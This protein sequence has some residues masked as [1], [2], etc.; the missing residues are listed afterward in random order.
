MSPIA[1]FKKTLTQQSENNTLTQWGI[2]LELAAKSRSP[3]VSSQEIKQHGQVGIGSAFRGNE[4]SGNFFGGG[5]GFLFGSQNFRVTRGGKA[6]E[7]KDEEG[8][9]T[10]QVADFAGA[11]AISDSVGQEISGRGQLLEMLK[12]KSGGKP[13]VAVFDAKLHKGSFVRSNGIFPEDE[14]ARRAKSTFDAQADQTR[15][16][17][18]VGGSGNK[19]DLLSLRESLGSEEAATNDFSL[20]IKSEILLKPIDELAIARSDDSFREPR[21]EI[22][23]RDAAIKIQNFFKSK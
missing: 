21:T 13:F 2:P 3:K 5:E 16:G 20:T 23:V 22:Q 8:F 6:F 11:Q 4:Q 1:E 17:H 7:V 15:G 14:V 12:E 9:W 10:F 18:L 19:G